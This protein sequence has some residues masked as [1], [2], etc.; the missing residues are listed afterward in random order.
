MVGMVMP[1][2]EAQRLSHLSSKWYKNNRDDKEEIT[3]F[4]FV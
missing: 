2:K 3:F 1:K 4:I